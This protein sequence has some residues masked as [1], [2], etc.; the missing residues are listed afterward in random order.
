MAETII[1][2]TEGGPHPGH[3]PFGIDQIGWPPPGF[4]AD[5]GGRYYKVSESDLPPQK[6]DSIFVRAALYE[7]EPDKTIEG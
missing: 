2:S 5:Q 1:I 7:W 3:R 4:L 6:S